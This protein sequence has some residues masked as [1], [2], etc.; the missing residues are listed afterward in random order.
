MK[1]KEKGILNYQKYYPHELELDNIYA[2]Q[3]RT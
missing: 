2:L 3:M 1:T